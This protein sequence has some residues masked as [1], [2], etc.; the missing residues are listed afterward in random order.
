MSTCKFFLQGTCKFGDTC[1]FSHQINDTSQTHGTSILRQNATNSQKIDTNLLV[2]S[3]VTDMMNTEKGG[4]WL[5]SS[6]APFKEKPCFPGFENRSF[7]EVRLGY[8]EAMKNGSVEQYKQQL[9]ITLQEAAMKVKALQN[10][11]PEIIAMLVQIYNTSLEN[12]GSAS[13]PFG[14]TQNASVFG[15]NQNIFNQNQS[16]FN[17]TQPSSQINFGQTRPT[18]QIGFGQSPPQGT[19]IFAM[20]NQE[21]F[22]KSPTNQQ[23]SIFGVN[24]GRA[25]TNVFNTASP[26]NTSTTQS[27]FGT[28][29]SVFNN[30]QTFNSNT[31]NSIFAKPSFLPTTQRN[32][33][34]ITNSTFSSQPQPSAFQ[35]SSASN[36][37]FNNQTSSN[38]TVFPSTNPQTFSFVKAAANIASPPFGQQPQQPNLFVSSPPQQHASPFQQT[39]SNSPIGNSIFKTPTT[40]PSMFIAQPSVFSNQPINTEQKISTSMFNQAPVQNN[41]VFG[42]SAEVTDA[43]AYSKLEDLSESE[44][45]SFESAS[46]EF[47]KIPEKPPTAQMC[48]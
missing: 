28:N 23:Q 44:I 40:T 16:P 31:N 22:G 7:E 25:S 45:K 2:K 1:K 26:Q 41:N 32:N 34:F 12:Q 30:K 36:T 17:Q 33:G 46:F 21:L 43:S 5:L 13:T 48:L 37:P 6:Y 8:Y 35:N 29:P 18:N 14:T 9:Q 42:G 38:N 3:V 27:I 19:S 20:A 4:H 11:T 47:G 10:P 39:T 24:T 15:Q